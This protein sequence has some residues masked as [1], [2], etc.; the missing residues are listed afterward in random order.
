LDT[1]FAS[2]DGEGVHGLCGGDSGGPLL[3]TFGG[4]T[5]VVGDLNGGALSCVGVDDYARLDTQIDWIRS[6]IGSP[7]NC[8]TITEAGTCNGNVALYCDSDRLKSEA[9]GP[10]HLCEPGAV[11]G[12]AGCVENTSCGDLTETGICD[13][14]TARWCDN[15]EAQE[16]ACQPG[17]TCAFSASAGGNRCL[18]SGCGDVPPGGECRGSIARVC[19]DQ[20]PYEVDCAACGMVCV[21]SEGL[22]DCVAQ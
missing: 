2:V 4:E 3:G 19:V 13:A 7:A 9:C 16:Q 8:G 20:S 11:N 10:E 21:M 6:V 17:Q 14:Q 18:T 22:P 12:H 5:R 15:D 1:W